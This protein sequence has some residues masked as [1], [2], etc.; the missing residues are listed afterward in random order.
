MVAGLNLTRPIKS[1]PVPHHITTWMQRTL[2][3]ELVG[4][5]N[6]LAV[7][8]RPDIAFAVR[9]LASFLDCY[10][11]EHW[12]AAIHILWYVKGT[13]TLCLTLCGEN[14]LLLLGYANSDYANDPN[15]SCSISGYCYT[16]GT[17]MVS[18]SSKKQRLT[19][20]SSCY[21]E[22]IALHHAGKELI[23]LRKLLE[24]LGH[25]FFTR[26]PLHCD[27]NAARLL[28]GDHLNH[29]NVKHIYV[30]Y[31][32]ICDF[33]DEGFGHI[34]RIRLLDNI[35]DIFTKPLARDC[36]EHFQDSLGLHFS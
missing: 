17:G 16:L 4:S 28:T 20:D 1:Q 24:S 30:K 11:E 6:Y 18:W 22:Y 21:T 5:L 34:M 26:T 14:P 2:Y 3:R 36:F 35:T 32:T 7:A 23:F 29:G 9:C 31:H 13:C 33:V 19:A 12:N 15:T 10:R 27:N 8:T 25:P